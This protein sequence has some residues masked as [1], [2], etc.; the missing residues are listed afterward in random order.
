MK[1]WGKLR[2]GLRAGRTKKGQTEATFEEPTKPKAGGDGQ[3]EAPASAPPPPPPP[4]P[5]EIEIDSTPP[6]GRGEFT[7]EYPPNGGRDPTTGL[8][9]IPPQLGLS[10]DHDATKHDLPRIV[11]PSAN[12]QMRPG[13][14]LLSIQGTSLEA[15]EVDRQELCKNLLQKHIPIS[16]HDNPLTLT[17]RAGNAIDIVRNGKV[18]AAGLPG[19]FSMEGGDGDVVEWQDKDGTHCVQSG[20]NLMTYKDS[21]L[22]TR[23]FVVTFRMKLAGNEDGFGMHFNDSQFVWDN[24]KGSAFVEGSFFGAAPGERLEVKMP[25]QVQKESFNFKEM[26][27]LSIQK[28]KSHFTFLVNKTGLGVVNVEGEVPELE[29]LAVKEKSGGKYR[30][31][32]WCLWADENYGELPPLGD[33]EP[34]ATAEANGAPESSG[35]DDLPEGHYNVVCPAGKLGLHFKEDPVTH[36]LYVSRS[37]GILG[38]LPKQGDIVVNVNGT[39]VHSHDDM[40]ACES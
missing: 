22:S 1:A 8:V 30:V 29:R 13:D 17:F 35:D 9:S 16:T 14:M 20:A 4:P 27:D 28:H 40:D 31:Y 10:L 39:H 36:N 5:I 37:S 38:P 23:D 34:A 11:R 24:A 32:S 3:E 12:T 25:G 6:A 18:A 15:E 7:L 33:A 26:F 19:R 21:R 2:N